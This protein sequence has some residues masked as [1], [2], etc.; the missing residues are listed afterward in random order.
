MFRRLCERLD[1][2]QEPVIEL[3]RDLVSRVALGPE[4]GGIGE[5]DKGRCS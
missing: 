5:T 2:Y 3:Q 4:V 1:T